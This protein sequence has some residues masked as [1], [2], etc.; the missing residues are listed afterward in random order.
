M[1]ISDQNL[2]SGKMNII[3][4]LSVAIIPRMLK[5]KATRM[6]LISDT[7]V[8]IFLS[9]VEFMDLSMTAEIYM[10]LILRKGVEVYGNGEGL[11]QSAFPPYLVV[12]YIIAC[13]YNLQH[14]MI[15][16]ADSEGPD[17]TARTRRLVWAFVDHVCLGNE[18]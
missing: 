16:F 17:Q 4:M 6:F 11:Y 15:L 18:I 2:F 3:R 8:Q 10:G 1:Q 13:L 7:C 5:V 14:T 12:S 9:P